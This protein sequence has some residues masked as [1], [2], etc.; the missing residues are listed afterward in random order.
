MAANE[1]A[2][3]SGAGDLSGCAPRHGLRLCAPSAAQ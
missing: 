2:R 1:I 3:A